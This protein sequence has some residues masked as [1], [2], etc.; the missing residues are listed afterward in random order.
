[1]ISVHIAQMYF[2]FA[3]VLSLSEE[4]K[5]ISNFKMIYYPVHYQDFCQYSDHDNLIS[6]PVSYI[7]MTKNVWSIL[8]SYNKYIQQ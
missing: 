3:L 1:M 5:Q 8:S 7:K 6:L 4:N 2:G